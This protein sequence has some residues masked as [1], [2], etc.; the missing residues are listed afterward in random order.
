MAF[1]NLKW[2]SIKEG[3]AVPRVVLP[4]TTSRIARSALATMDPFEGH[5]VTAFAREQGQDDIYVNTATFHGFID[6]A[7]SEWS[8]PAGFIRRLRLSIQQSVYPGD[9]MYAEGKVVRHYEGDDGAGLV[10]ID[11]EVGT[12]RGVC[13]P[14]FVT[15]EL[16]R[17]EKD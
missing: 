12:G 14:A 15:L 7:I 9:E 16:P 4:I 6:R 5:H 1:E 8:G 11:L 3:D 13:C 10:D 17:G 2:S